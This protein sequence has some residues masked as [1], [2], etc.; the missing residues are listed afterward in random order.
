MRYRG[1]CNQMEAMGMKMPPYT[2]VSQCRDYE[3]L[4]RKVCALIEEHPEIDGFVCRNDHLACVVMSAVHSMGKS[5]PEEICIVGFDNSSMC[6][7]VQ[8]ALSSIDFDRHKIAAAII[9][10][11]ESMV[12]GGN[13]RE[14]HFATN[15]VLRGSTRPDSKK[16]S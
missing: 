14:Q 12:E 3:A 4:H 2:L 16:E 8:P 6:T 15:L 10:M 1:F 7:V 13:V 5:I 9:E 11:I